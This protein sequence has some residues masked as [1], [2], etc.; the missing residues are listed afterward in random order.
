M[1]RTLE[2]IDDSIIFVHGIQGH[3]KRTWAT[4]TNQKSYHL[5]SRSR[6]QGQISKVFRDP[7]ARAASQTQIY[8]TADA[9]ASHE[10]VFWPR[11]LLPMDC[12]EA[13]I[14]TWGYESHVSRF[15][16]GSVDQGNIF[17]HAK[18]LLYALNRVRQPC[19]CL[20][21][22]TYGAD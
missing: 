14:L 11:D 12:S 20:V 1:Q 7:T 4:K 9:R 3:P 19:V 8:G 17:D 21:M 22:Y 16:A 15:F 13:R 5:P 10:S 18:N 2:L 6:F